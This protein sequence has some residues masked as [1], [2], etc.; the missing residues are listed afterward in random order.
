MIFVLKSPHW[1]IR[2]S[3]FEDFLLVLLG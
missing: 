3:D 2:S 1:F